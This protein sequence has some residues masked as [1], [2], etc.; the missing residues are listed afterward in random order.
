MGKL[1]ILINL[2][3]QK[4]LN[5]NKRSS[6]RK[7][8]FLTLLKED[9]EKCYKPYI[10]YN[11]FWSV[12][13]NDIEQYE[14]E[15]NISTVFD[16]EEVDELSS[17]NYD[18]STVLLDG[19][20]NNDETDASAFEDTKYDNDE[21]DAS[22]FENTNHEP[23]HKNPA[24]ISKPIKPR[25]LFTDEDL[26]FGETVLNNYNNIEISNALAKL[27]NEKKFSLKKKSYS[28]FFDLKKYLNN[29]NIYKFTKN[30]YEGTRWMQYFSHLYI[31]H[32]HMKVKKY[33]ADKKAIHNLNEPIEFEIFHFPHEADT[34]DLVDGQQKN[35]VALDIDKH[36]HAFLDQIVH[37]LHKVQNGFTGFVSNYV[38]KLKKDIVG[39][40]LATVILKNKNKITI[41]IIDSNNNERIHKTNPFYRNSIEDL[42]SEIETKLST[43]YR[44]YYPMDHAIQWNYVL[45]DKVQTNIEK[46]N[47]FSQLAYCSLIAYLILDIFYTN[48]VVYKN[49]SANASSDTVS[50]Y[51]QMIQ[52][53]LNSEFKI[54][55]KKDLFFLYLSNYCYFILSPLYVQSNINKLEKKLYIVSSLNEMKK[56]KGMNNEKQMSK[57]LCKYVTTSDVLGTC[58]GL[59]YNKKD[60]VDVFSEPHE[61]N[62]VEYFIPRNIFFTFQDKFVLFESI[63]RQ[64]RVK[65]MQDMLKGEQI[66][67]KK[68]TPIQLSDLK[69]VFFN[70]KQLAKFFDAKNTKYS[71]VAK[72]RTQTTSRKK[73]P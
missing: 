63:T 65:I 6:E 47:D 21:T 23:L 14:A 38:L 64:R 32:K 71:K 54:E 12:L 3:K 31:F 7:H 44:K 56:T 8:R 50:Y 57:L 13:S 52:Q 51:L 36:C 39:H 27:K 72:L 59:Q 45:V 17:Y 18:E 34:I 2:Y 58:I 73:K 68:V 28:I 43:M 16:S 66:D 19:D 53:H 70:I 10:E 55:K 29:S 20:T 22:A 62:G 9:L 25:D 37:Y 5:D 60:S 61:T 46:Y 40:A 48:V 35:T 33:L 42:A 11:I 4:I 49:I 24:V 69:F 67:K 30:P 41:F 26:K 1:D 15:L